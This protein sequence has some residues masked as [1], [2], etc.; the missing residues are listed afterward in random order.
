[1]AVEVAPVSSGIGATFVQRFRGLLAT[2]TAIVAGLVIG[3]LALAAAGAPPLAAY[4]E[5]AR[6]ALGS[7]FGIYQ[8]LDQAVPLAIIGIGLCVPFR[9]GIWNIGAEGQFYMGALSGGL[10][11]IYLPV[12]QPVLMIPL[13]FAAAMIGGGAWAYVAGWLRAHSG[14]NEIVSTLMLNYIGLFVLLYLVRIPFRDPNNLIIQS[15]V[16]TE[17]ARLNDLPGTFVHAG[18]LVALLLVPVVWWLL[19]KT[20]FGFRVGVMGLNPD[21]AEAAGVDTK[22]TIKRVMLISGALAGLAGIVQVSAVQ[23]VVNG[24]ISRQFGFTAIVVALLGR[25]NPIGAFL[26]AVFLG[27]IAVG[28]V[29]V[30]QVYQIPTAILLAVQA[31][32]VFLLLAAER[33]MSR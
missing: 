16:V 8:S 3:G 10:V 20:P 22:K 23:L 25:R 2:L 4:G 5:L 21:A 30:Q 29:S 14:V 33:L 11:G 7:S 32:F 6:G 19:H 24:A 13:T 18:I 17:A 12:D 9:A 28:G 31:L 26:A 15:R 27:M 1:M